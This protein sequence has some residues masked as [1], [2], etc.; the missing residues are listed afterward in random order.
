MGITSFEAVKANCG[1][2]YQWEFNNSTVN[3]NTTFGVDLLYSWTTRN[4]CGFSWSES[5]IL[6][7]MTWQCVA[8]YTFFNLTSGLCQDFCGAFTF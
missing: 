4:T 8:P 2:E 5:S 1:F 6:Y 7:M 3:G